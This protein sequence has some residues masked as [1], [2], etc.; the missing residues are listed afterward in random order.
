MIRVVIADDHAIVRHGLKMMLETHDD[1]EVVCE[2]SNGK[3]A[4]E[5]VAEHAPDVVV[6][7]ISMP[8]MDGVTATHQIVEY[9]PETKVLILSMHEEMSSIREISKIGASGFLAKSA[10]PEELLSAVQAASRGEFYLQPEIASAAYI[11]LLKAPQEETVL[12]QRELDVVRMLAR[13]SN[14]NEI[15]KAL[16]ISPRTVQAH[17]YH[18]TKKLGLHSKQD[19]V[20]YAIREG[21]VDLDF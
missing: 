15:A 10:A 14:V 9:H 13:E 7:D 6:M 2:C 12:T 3:E 19:L 16:F 20:M 17:L 4:V 8:V 11:D 1:I 21:L 5:A 18:A